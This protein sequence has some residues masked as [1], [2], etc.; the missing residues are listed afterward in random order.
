MGGV[1]LV[2]GKFTPSQRVFATTG[3]K[4]ST[5]YWHVPVIDGKVNTVLDFD[6]GIKGDDTN[7]PTGATNFSCV[8]HDTDW[9]KADTGE[10]RVDVEDRDDNTNIG[11][12]TDFGINFLLS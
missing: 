12:G 10:F 7:E 3:T 4:Q 2:V 6:F 11:R 9:F 8:F 5:I 1:A